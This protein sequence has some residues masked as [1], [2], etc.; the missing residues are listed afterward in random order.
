VCN[1]PCACFFIVPSFQ[2]P[3]SEAPTLSLSGP[4][5]QN[6][7]EN[8]PDAA[9]IPLFNATDAGTCRATLTLAGGETYSN[10]FT[11]VPE[12]YACG[13]NPHGC[14]EAFV[15]DAGTSW[16]IDNTCTSANQADA[17]SGDVS[18]NE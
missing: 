17:P 2:C 9:S 18:V 8:K 12:W 4:C 15:S 16:N 7:T 5:V 1:C 3:P 14:G 11:F 10:E 6:G 13:S